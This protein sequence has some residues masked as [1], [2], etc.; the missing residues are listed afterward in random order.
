M[1][2]Y[3]GETAVP[4]SINKKGGTGVPPL[5]LLAEEEHDDDDQPDRHAEEP[6]SKTT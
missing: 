4:H 6:E 1:S 2:N 3:K 5:A